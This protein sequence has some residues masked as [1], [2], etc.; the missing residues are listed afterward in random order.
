MAS[1]GPAGD[2]GNSP[3]QTLR[4]GGEFVVTGI[5][6]VGRVVV[7]KLSNL[8]KEQGQEGS[9]A[10]GGFDLMDMSAFVGQQLRG[11]VPLKD[12]NSV[13]YIETM[14]V[15]PDQIL[16]KRQLLEF[17]VLRRRNVR[18]GQRSDLL[19]MRHAHR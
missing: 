15:R 17:G 16:L 5:E 7:L 19:G 4:P 2:D 8:L 12:Q 3:G 10:P 13:A 6:F 11:P 1:S 14:R 18:H 9:K